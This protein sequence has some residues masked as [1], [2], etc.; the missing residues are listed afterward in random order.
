MKVF[1]AYANFDLMLWIFVC[2]A[3]TGLL[4]ALI[5]PKKNQKC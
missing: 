4:M 3:A 2:C 5:R 1:R